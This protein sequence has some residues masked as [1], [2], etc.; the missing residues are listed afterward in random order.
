MWCFRMDIYN[1]LYIWV[2]FRTE[3]TAIPYIDAEFNIYS[4]VHHAIDNNII[5][6]IIILELTI[7]YI[8]M[9]HNTNVWI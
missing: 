4:Y 7:V 9:R 8:D 2:F 5:Y 6:L 1:I 3:T